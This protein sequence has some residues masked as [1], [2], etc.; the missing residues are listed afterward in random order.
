MRAE[1]EELYLDSW[2]GLICHFKK[3]T[4]KFQLWIK[5]GKKKIHMHTISKNK[6]KVP[7][8]ERHLAILEFL[9]E[10][11]G[12]MRRMKPRILLIPAFSNSTANWGRWFIVTGLAEFFQETPPLQCSHCSWYICNTFCNS[13]CPEK[14]YTYTGEHQYPL[15]S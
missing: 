3:T 2:S 1:K 14:K 6:T 11:D 13:M 7:S 4:A 9:M 15:S 8:S 10:T 12:S 5:R